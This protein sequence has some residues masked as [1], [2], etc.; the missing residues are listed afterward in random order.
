[1]SYLN[2][3]TYLEACVKQEHATLVSPIF[4]TNPPYIYCFY[5]SGKQISV[6]VK[7][8]LNVYFEHKTIIME[9]P[10]E[11]SGEDGDFI[12]NISDGFRPGPRYVE[13]IAV[14]LIPDDNYKCMRIEAI[15]YSMGSCVSGIG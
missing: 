2:A 7:L 3:G 13:F 1:M 5:V 6:H 15:Q 11:Y 4:D 10:D 14:P 9:G 12:I 8:V